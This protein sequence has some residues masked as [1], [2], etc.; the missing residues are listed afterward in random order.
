MVTRLQRAGLP[1][2]EITGSK[3]VCSYPMLIAAYHVLLRLQKPRHPP[4]ALVTFV[5]VS[6]DTFESQ[7]LPCLH[8]FS[9]FV[10]LWNCSP[11]LD[12]DFSR[13]PDSLFSVIDFLFRF[14][15]SLSLSILSNNSSL[16]LLS[17][18]LMYP[19]QNF[20]KN[21]P[22]LSQTGCKD[23]DFFLTSKFFLNIFSKK[24][25][26]CQNSEIIPTFVHPIDNINSI[27]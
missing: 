16:F 3:P 18:C 11:Q 24:L 5:S 13:S 9:C 17:G 15:T 22:F 25:I 4:S 8:L 27:K 6:L 23:T 26:F 10:C 7:E 2:S 20:P 19:S 12:S 14:F 21:F 1:H